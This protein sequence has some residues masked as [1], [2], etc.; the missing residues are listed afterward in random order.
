MKAGEVGT[1]HRCLIKAKLDLLLCEVVHGRAH[2]SYLAPDWILL[3]EGC[4]EI[5]RPSWWRRMWWWLWKYRH[6]RSRMKK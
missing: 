3:C 1:C 4:Q 2:E 5:M 6:Y